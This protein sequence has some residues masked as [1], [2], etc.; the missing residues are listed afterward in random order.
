MFHVID[1]VSPYLLIT[2]RSGNLMPKIL[3]SIVLI[4]LGQ[5]EI[6]RF[7]PRFVTIAGI[8]FHSMLI[9]ARYLITILV[10]WCKVI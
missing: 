7:P 8:E 4:Q 6:R 1:K 3:K 5:L 2:M 10:S 9:I